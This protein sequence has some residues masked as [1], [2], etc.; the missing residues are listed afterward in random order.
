VTDHVLLLWRNSLRL[1]P[2]NTVLLWLLVITGGA[3]QVM[4]LLTGVRTFNGDTRAVRRPDRRVRH[5]R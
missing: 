1:A 4:T 3:A 2:G 5:A